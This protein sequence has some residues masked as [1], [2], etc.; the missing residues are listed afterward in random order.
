LFPKLPASPNAANHFTATVAS[1]FQSYGNPALSLHNP[2]HLDFLSKGK[3]QAVSSIFV[4][5][6]AEC[7]E[8]YDFVR[9]NWISNIHE[10]LIA[11][12]TISKS[13]V[14]QNVVKTRINLYIGSALVHLPFVTSLPTNLPA[15]SRTTVNAPN[16]Q[17]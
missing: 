14:A 11:A 9:E 16:L 15:A 7:K 10:E 5:V 13:A 2:A 12:G 6:L 4:D 1:K 17:R 8:V 3:D